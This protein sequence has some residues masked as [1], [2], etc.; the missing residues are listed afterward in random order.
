MPRDNWEEGEDLSHAEAKE[1]AKEEDKVETFP[2]AEEGVDGN[3]EGDD[4]LGLSCLEE[5]P[6]EASSSYV[7]CLDDV[8][9]WC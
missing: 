1:E 5:Q 4:P 3:H 9:S 6:V 8:W 7:L 2:E